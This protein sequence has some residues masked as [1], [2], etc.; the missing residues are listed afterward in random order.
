MQTLQVYEGMHWGCPR[1]PNPS[2]FPPPLSTELHAVPDPLPPSKPPVLCAYPPPPNTC[3]LWPSWKATTPSV[4]CTVLPPTCCKPWP[5]GPAFYVAPYKCGGFL[6]A[7]GPG[8]LS[9]GS[10]PH[11]E[12]GYLGTGIRVHSPSPPHPTRCMSARPPARP[13]VCLSVC[14]S[15][16]LSLSLVLSTL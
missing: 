2:L 10:S 16:S 3:T 6:L 15:V 5:G 9:V 13:S 12:K 11:L 8:G 7:A 14:L 1:P 4:L